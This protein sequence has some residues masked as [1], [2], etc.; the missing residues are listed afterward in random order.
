MD[1][2][3][4]AALIAALATLI[5][6]GG[7]VA[8]AITAARNTRRTNQ[9]TIDAAHADAQLTLDAA[10]EAQ[11]ADR[12][13]RA[14]EQV[15][16]TNLY[17]R[18]GGIYALEGIAHDSPRH[19]PTVMEF[20]TD[21]IRGHSRMPPDGSRPERWPLPDVQAALAVVCRRKAKHDVNLEGADLSSAN[22]GSA[23]LHNASLRTANLTSANL[24]N[25]DLR[26]AILTGAILTNAIL[27][28]A[29][30]TD[31]DLTDADLTLADFSGANLTS[32][33]F[34]NAKLEAAKLN[35]ANLTRTLFSWANLAR[36]D[37]L[38]ADLSDTIF[39]NVV[40]TKARLW[41]AKIRSLKLISTDLTDDVDFNYAEWPANLSVPRGWIRDRSS[42]QLSNPEM[43]PPRRAAP[44]PVASRGLTGEQR[45][46]MNERRE[47][48]REHRRNQFGNENLP[49]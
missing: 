28:S 32:A 24:A 36:A 47:R 14:L 7:T 44:G 30:L 19:H 22:L 11:F 15:G 2:T 31:A 39:D 33:R 20:L 10:R 6:V 9:A 4:G 29:D 1:P 43:P 35:S 5:G 45:L 18:I 16:S 23:N 38:Y 21:F 25:A 13:S 27:E 37:L 34:I 49:S 17:V 41:H 3:F 42:G 12:Y 8:V 46:E 40:L 26:N 48:Q